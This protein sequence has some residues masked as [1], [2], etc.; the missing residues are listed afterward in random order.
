MPKLTNVKWEQ[1]A[2]NLAAGLTVM[3]AYENAG[4]PRSQ[5]SASQLKARPEVIQRVNE[6][7]EDRQEAATRAGEDFTGIP[8][9]LNKE[10]VIRMLMKNVDIAQTQGQISAA[11][12]AVEILAEIIGVK[13]KKGTKVD[14]DDDSK[15]SPVNVDK[16]TEAFS[17]LTDMLQARDEAVAA[18]EIE[19]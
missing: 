12:K 15:P 6:I 13:S 11:N 9:E 7:L 18:G 3:D 16:L 4:Y 8:A 10:W 17:G 1:F 2:Q 19:K 14:D 5:S